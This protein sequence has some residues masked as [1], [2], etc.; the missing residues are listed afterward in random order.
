MTRRITNILVLLA[1]VYWASGLGECL[2]EKFEHHHEKP[3]AVEPGK[4]DGS[5]PLKEADDHDDCVI[6][7]T[8]KAMTAH[9]PC[10][11]HC[12]SP[13]CQALRLFRS[14]SSKRRCLRLWCSSRRVRRRV[15]RHRL[16]I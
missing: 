5:K 7:Q 3:Q 2:H 13:P 4:R 14:R 8:L 9:Q 12:P 16:R 11:R 15:F 6:C 1:F 10:R